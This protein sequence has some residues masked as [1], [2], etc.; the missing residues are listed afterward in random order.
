MERRCKTE[1]CLI[2]AKGRKD[3]SVD[4]SHA[5]IMKNAK[6]EWSGLSR[7]KIKVAHDRK[8]NVDWGN[9]NNDN[10]LFTHATIVASVDTDG[11]HQIKSA[12]NELINNNGNAWTNEVMLACFRSFQGAENYY[13]H[14]QIPE[15]SK[16][17]ILDSVIKPVKYASENGELADVYYVDILVATN[18]RHEDLVRRIGNGELSTMSMGCI[19]NVCTC[20]RCGK[21]LKDNDR[22]CHHLDNQM[23]QEYID[24]QG[25]K[26]VVAE[27]CGRTFIDPITKKKVG[28]PKSVEFI[29]DS[30]VEKTAFRGAV[31][32][33]YVSDVS[34]V[35]KDIIG[36]SDKKLEDLMDDLFKV[37]VASQDAMIALRVAHDELRRR[38]WETMVNNV[39]RE[40]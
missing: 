35:A 8:L 30:W 29:E 6:S 11:T 31:I 13:E 4:F 23:R 34:K 32:N 9:F 40:W 3:F 39:S 14:V 10:Y 17:K 24:H 18:R 38:K 15:L 21:E 27:L 20:S 2:R 7:N 22:N 25:N 12:C 33:H 28:D 16:G 26:R 19:A 37:R 1:N 36:F 5:T